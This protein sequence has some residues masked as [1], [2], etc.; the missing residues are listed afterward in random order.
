MTTVS[1]TYDARLDWTGNT[2]EG[3]A[4]YDG[5]GRRWRVRTAGKPDLEGSAAR[6]FLGDPALH[7][8]E[9]LFVAAITTCHML[10]YLA[11]CA[12]HGVKVVG[13]ED[14]AR[15]TLVLHAG[16]GGR[17][18][19]VV[20]NPRVTVADPSH[21]DLALSLHEAAHDRCFIATSCS[22]PVRHR[23]SVHVA[24]V[25]TTAGEGRERPCTT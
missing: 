3:T 10:A 17:F 7:D 18:E 12:R 15:G 23:P 14:D 4:R 8:P 22:T 2:G 16:G 6:I 24:G 20:L 11:L 19:E 25:S 21:A 5:Y 9:D 1:H 13:Y